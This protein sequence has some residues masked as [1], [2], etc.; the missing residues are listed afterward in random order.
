MRKTGFSIMLKSSGTTLVEILVVLGLVAIMA[1][2]IMSLQSTAIKSMTSNR[3]FSSRDT[4]KTLADRY[5]LDV[6]VIGK[7]AV[8]ANY[9]H[10]GGNKNGNQALDYCLNGTPTTPP[11]PA[12]AATSEA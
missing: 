9:N 11:L 2:G 7:S 3:Q 8:P 10:L 4:L 5:V 6:S 12:C 1:L